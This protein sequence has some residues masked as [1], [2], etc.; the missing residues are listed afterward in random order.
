MAAGT[1]TR[2]PR[3]SPFPLFEPGRLRRGTSTD[4]MVLSVTNVVGFWISD[5]SQATTWCGY[6]THYP[7]VRLTGP[8]FTEPSSFVTHRGSGPMT[9]APLGRLVAVFGSG[10]RELA[11]I[12]AEHGLAR[13]S[14][15]ASPT[16]PRSR[17]ARDR[18]SS[19]IVDVRDDNRLPDELAGFKRRHPATSLVLVTASLDPTLILDA[20]RAGVSECLT[21][22]LSAARSRRQSSV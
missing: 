6:I 20:M 22:P 9:P 1:C 8:G 11:E 10:D 16:S 7:T 21:D 5:A 12:V 3:L 13:C 2:S 19:R 4:N 18:S 15:C 14:R 17:P